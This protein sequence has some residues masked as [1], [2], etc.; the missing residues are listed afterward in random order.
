MSLQCWLIVSGLC[1]VS[2]G[3][4]RETDGHAILNLTYTS[5]LGTITPIKESQSSSPMNG[6]SHSH[7]G[8]PQIDL[9]GSLIPVGV[10]IRNTKQKPAML[11][12]RKCD[13][14]SFSVEVSTNKGD[15][16][17]LT[18]FGKEV[19]SPDA[20]LLRRADIAGLAVDAETPQK[21]LI[22]NLGLFFD[23]T[24]PGEYLVTISREVKLGE[25]WASKKVV[26]KCPQYSSVTQP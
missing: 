2:Q 5:P 9:C 11:E 4:Q 18:R 16:V 20:K 21:L 3:I 10:L 12:L 24:L 6:R 19:L 1:L 14:T 25:A 22:N 23:L 15:A 26:L 7:R 17:P 8:S 13:P